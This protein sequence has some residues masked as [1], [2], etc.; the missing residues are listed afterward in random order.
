MLFC[1]LIYQL[2]RK[3][4]KITDPILVNISYL[5]AKHLNHMYVQIIIINDTQLGR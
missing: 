3:Q 1:S 4:I 2:K 5:N